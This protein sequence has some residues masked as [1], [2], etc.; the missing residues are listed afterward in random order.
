ML[1]AP[2]W[3]AADERVELSRHQ[4]IRQALADDADPRVGEDGGRLGARQLVAAAKGRDESARAAPQRRCVQP[5]LSVPAGAAGPDPRRRRREQP[6]D[7]RRQH[8]VPGRPQHVGAQD[9]AGREGALDRSVVSTLRAHPD[10]PLGGAVVLRLDGAE[11]A[12]DRLGRR[13]GGAGQAL[14][15]QPARKDRPARLS[16]QPR[17]PPAG[18]RPHPSSPL[19]RAR[20]RSR[21]PCRRGRWGRRGSCPS[22]S[23]GP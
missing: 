1:S 14:R 3:A 12:D 9:V 22:S 4:Q 21:C 11:E 16:V 2:S 7:V 6:A 20:S 8:E 19:P 15:A 23:R 17:S 13:A 5:Q 18:Q 10:G